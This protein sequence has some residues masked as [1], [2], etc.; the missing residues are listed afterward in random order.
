MRWIQENPE[1]VKKIAENGRQFYLDY[2]DFERNEEH[3]YEFLYRL[4]E[5]KEQQDN[6]TTS[7]S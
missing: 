5:T 6:N 3:I 7:V 1:K 2:L 4:A